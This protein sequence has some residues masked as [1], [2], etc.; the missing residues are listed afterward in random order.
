ME[1]RLEQEFQTE[2]WLEQSQKKDF[3]RG[4]IR[5]FLTMRGIDPDD[6]MELF[7]KAVEKGTG[8]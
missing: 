8:K 7:R 5:K 1:N 6:F 2:R 4:A 3:V